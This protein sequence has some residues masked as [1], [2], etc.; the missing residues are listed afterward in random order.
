MLLKLDAI[1]AG[2][3]FSKNLSSDDAAV[4]AEN[5]AVDD[6]AI[7][8]NNAIIVKRVFVFLVA[9]EILFAFF[10]RGVFIIIVL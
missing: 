4:V 6:T 8:T 3:L 9:P 1:G 2:R 7:K 10:G 5:T